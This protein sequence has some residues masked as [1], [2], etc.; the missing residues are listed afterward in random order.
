MTFKLPTT[1]ASTKYL[2]DELTPAST[3]VISS[4]LIPSN[5][6]IRL[7]FVLLGVSETDA[8]HL[9]E[10]NDVSRGCVEKM[11]A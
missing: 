6:A 7:A 1:Q 2:T 11:V 9:R 3:L 10:T 4:T 5:G 8:K